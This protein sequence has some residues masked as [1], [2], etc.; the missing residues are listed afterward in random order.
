[1]TLEFFGVKTAKIK[2]MISGDLPVVETG[3]LRT[4]CVFLLEDNTY[5]HL[6]FESSYKKDNLVRFAKYD[7]YLYERDNRKI[8]TIVIYSADVKT[9][10]TS[11]E[12]GSLTYT[13]NVV[14]MCDYD[15][16]AVYAELEAKLNN[17][18][19]LS[20]KDML[21]LI[22]LPLMRHNIPKAELAKKS[23]ELAKTISDRT[24]SEACIAST[25]AFAEKYLNEAEIKQIEEAFKMTGIFTRLL[26]EELTKEAEKIA[27][28]LLKKGISV[29]DIAD[30]T[31][32]DVE[33]V[34]ELQ[35][36][37]EQEAEENAE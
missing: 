2:D 36:Q 32:L 18:Q 12:I 17:G 11:L 3:I 25:I 14:M 8:N 5:Q 28:K 30:S 23:I 6:E 10:D 31:N 29:D 35:E 16:N 27:I 21:N 9:A 13:P 37:L 15:G 22:F 7:L 4:D 26:T 24:K 33:A 19:E 20:E 1:M 34:K